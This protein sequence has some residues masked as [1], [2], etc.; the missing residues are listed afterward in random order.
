MPKGSGNNLRGPWVIFFGG[1]FGRRID[2]GRW[3]LR[4]PV[5]NFTL[6]VFVFLLPGVV[7]S[8]WVVSKRR[9]VPYVKFMIDKST[10]VML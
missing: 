7:S 1:L 8:G 5:I 3:Y 6:F 10:A 9:V 4:T 2:P